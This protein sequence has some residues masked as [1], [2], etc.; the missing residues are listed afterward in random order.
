MSRGLVWFRD[1]LRLADNEPLVK[2]IE[3]NESVL[4]VVVLNEKYWENTRWGFSRTG[5]FRTQ[6][7]HES[8]SALK[9]DLQAIGGDLLI[10]TGAPEEVIPALVDE[11]NISTVYAPAAFSFD[12]RQE[13]KRLSEIIDLKLFWSSS[14]IHP[15]DLHFEID[16]L[17]DIFTQFRKKIEKYSHVRTVFEEPTSIA[18]PEIDYTWQVPQLNLETDSRSVLA[19]NGGEIEALNRLQNYFWE[20]ENV[21]TYKETRNG[22][23][24]TDY[25][26][27]LSPWLAN[28][29][30][31]P[32]TIY[33][34]LKRF[35]EEITSNQSTYWIFFELLWRDFFRYVSLKFGKHLF[36]K[37]GLK[38]E[39]R[40]FYFNG[41]KFEQW[42]TGTTGQP[43]V[44][45]N[46][47]ELLHTGF[48]S[49]RG[50]QNVASYLV[51]DMGLD[52]RAGAAWFEC[53]LID[54]DPSSNYG[55][56]LYVAGLGND[57]RPNRKF[58][59]ER[60]ASMY[61]PDGKYV[62]TWLD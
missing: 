59:V 31:S 40:K 61:D 5:M 56:W 10:V 48:M 25:S 8:F 16:S 2:A 7:L 28:G 32:R 52:W 39:P 14:L 17:P 33:W 42:R 15:D 3:E 55:N 51:H 4:P 19:F 34:E 43:F 47:R 13:E 6:F 35:E 21:S 36:L 60:Q 22:L 44:D 41:N 45:A 30:I 12:E 53:Q 37:Q 20:T 9:T 58:N 50:R 18:I 23:L 27:K 57:P 62:N 26:S 11:H 54:Y 38:N 29:S 49:N 46:M 1:N 24:G